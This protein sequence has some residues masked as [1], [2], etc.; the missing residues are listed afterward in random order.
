MWFIEVIIIFNVKAYKNTKK[1]PAKLF[2]NLFLKKKKGWLSFAEACISYYFI[3]L[4]F[5]PYVLSEKRGEG[6]ESQ[7]L[8]PPV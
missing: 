7:D 3:S 5:V 4:N 1:N 6:D 8:K 2:R